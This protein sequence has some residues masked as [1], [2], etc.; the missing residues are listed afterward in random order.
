MK[1][2]ATAHA[3]FAVVMMVKDE[4][5]II[6]KSVKRWH[7]LGAKIYICDNGSTDG[8]FEFLEYL[9]HNGI[10]HYLESDPEKAYVMHERIGRLKDRAIDDGAAWIFPADADEFWHFGGDTVPEYLERLGANEGDW[11]K[12]LYFDV[13]PNAKKWLVYPFHKCFGRLTKE[14]EICIGNHFVTTGEGKDCQG[15]II[16]HFPVRSFAQMK[17]KLINHMEA[18]AAA[19][20]D[21][22]HRQRIAEWQADPEA[23]FAKMWKRYN[24]EK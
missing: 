11:F 3:D 13:A 10:V 7:S 19:G 1:N 4:G 17:K 23:F 12:V 22:P 2:G 14:Q 24:F 5:D 16:E 18:F 9:Q 20:Y 8:T 15:L 6:E 21:H